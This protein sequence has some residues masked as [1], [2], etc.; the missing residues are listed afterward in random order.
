MRPDPGDYR[1]RA[2]DIYITEGAGRTPQRVIAHPADDRYP[3]WS[4]DA[5]ALA[6]IRI[7]GRHLRRDAD[8]R[9]DDRRE[10]RVA[11][12]GNFEE[13]RVSWSADGEWLVESFAPGPDPIRGWQIARISTR[14]RRA[15]RADAAQPRHARRL[16]AVGVSRRHAHRVRARHQRRHR[17]IFT[18]SRSAAAR[19]R[20]SPGTTRIS[21]ASTGAPTAARCSTPPIAP[22]ATPSGACRARRRRRRSSSSAAPRS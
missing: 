13:P 17:P 16:L 1:E 4:L 15:R 5:S 12:C 6:F 3:A 2:A 10:R 14:D 18:S 22:A 20:A 7:D 8:A 19:R 21:S 11:A 9:F